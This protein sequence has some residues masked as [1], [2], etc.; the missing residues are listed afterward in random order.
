MKKE[1]VSKEF[2]I[3]HIITRAVEGRKIFVAPGECCRSIFQMYAANI[4]KP[5]PNLH[6]K[7]VMKAGQAL[8]YGEQI[9]ERFIIIEHPPLVNI[10]SF[11][12]VINHEHFI[13]V[14]NFENGISKYMQKFKT[15]F[16]M[17]YNLKNK[18]RG[19]LFEKP[20]KMIQIQTD[21]QLT[22]VL[23]YINVKNPL[24]VYQPGWRE[25]GLKDWKE[26]FN[27]L[28]SYQFSSFPDLFGNRESKVLAPK[29]ILERYLGEKIIKDK[30]EFR[31]FVEAYLQD[32]MRRYHSFFLE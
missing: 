21:S 26:A 20:Y 5:A 31:S 17:Y 1:V 13:L 7:D 9:P 25:E 32:K 27:F 3:Y 4:G 14:P 6:R 29:E 30:K 19:N 22:A 8:L 24:D 28:E 11:A 18:R 12:Q 23:L 16:A 10:F 15:G 2:G